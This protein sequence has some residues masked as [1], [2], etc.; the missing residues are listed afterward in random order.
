MSRSFGRLLTVAAALLALPASAGEIRIGLANPLT[1]PL[2]ASG[3][4][5]R[6]AVELAIRA[7][8]QD[9]G[10]LGQPLQLVAVDDACGTDRA[11]A[12][13]LELV[14]AGVRFAVGHLCSHSS[15]MA[16]PIYEAVG[17]PMISPDSTHP[18]LTEEGRPN[19][20]RLGGRDDEQGRIAG[21][22]LAARPDARRVAIVHDESTYGRGLAAKTRARLRRHGVEELLFAGYTPG[23]PDYRD[24]ME[25]VRQAGAALLYVGGYGPD[26]GRIVRSARDLGY[27][28]QLV[29]GDGLATDEFWAAAGPAGNGTVFTARPDPPA[30]PLVESLLAAFEA[31]G[32]GRL[33]TGLGAYAAVQV[34]AEAAARSGTVDPSTVAETLHRGRFQSVLGPVAF[35]AKGDLAG[36]GWQWQIWNDGSF[37]PL[38]GGAEN[39]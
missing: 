39:L 9:G 6:V 25:H 11:A 17:V 33:P 24:L 13:A 8:N 5:N 31:L 36:A 21:D 32:L 29:G 27:G 35:D 20:F 30:E 18:R 4:R 7:L 23:Q 38:N 15:L 26:A 10:V 37:Q 16:A 1:G 19:V 3:Q 34:W 2:A 14:E 12:A 22:W 28:V